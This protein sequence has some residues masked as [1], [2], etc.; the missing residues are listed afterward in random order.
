MIPTTTLYESWFKYRT[1][2]V[3]VCEAA[4][5][6]N[7][8]TACRVWV[9][10]LNLNRL[11]QCQHILNLLPEISESVPRLCSSRLNPCLVDDSEASPTLSFSY[12]LLVLC[13]I[14]QRSRNRDSSSLCS[15]WLMIGNG[16]YY[17]VSHFVSITGTEDE[18]LFSAQLSHIISLTYTHKIHNSTYETGELN[19]NKTTKT[20]S[21]LVRAVWPGPA[22]PD[23][24][25]RGGCNLLNPPL[26]KNPF[27]R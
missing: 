23:K 15:V 26:K 7:F 2:T 13:I 4:L 22:R 27:T 14:V 8:H 6:M 1:H 20:V 11:N 5:S 18:R 17:R 12:I 16:V 19:G 10:S 24:L 25:G 3:P 9:L 21:P